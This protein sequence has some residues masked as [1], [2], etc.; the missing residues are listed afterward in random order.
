M[1]RLLRF[2]IKDR[3]QWDDEHPRIVFPTLW[4]VIAAKALASR[5]SN[6]DIPLNDK[7]PNNAHNRDRRRNFSQEQT[8]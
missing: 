6:V 8:S 1:D 4:D 7:Q 5:S 2:W 3:S